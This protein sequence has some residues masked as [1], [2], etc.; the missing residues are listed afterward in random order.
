MKS[1]NMYAIGRIHARFDTFVGL[2]PVKPIRK[3]I[4][5]DSQNINRT[6]IRVKI[7]ETVGAYKKD[8]ILEIQSDS[9]IPLKQIRKSKNSFSKILSNYEWIDL[10]PEFYSHETKPHY[11]GLH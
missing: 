3:I 8:E 2:I 6:Y 7:L 4:Y 5:K 10:F 1:I 9:I 11:V